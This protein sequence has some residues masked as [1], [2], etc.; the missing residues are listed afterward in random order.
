[1][2]NEAFFVLVQVKDEPCRSDGVLFQK[3]CNFAVLKF[4]GLIVQ[5]IE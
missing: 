3:N 2:S 5:G 4:Y 1:M